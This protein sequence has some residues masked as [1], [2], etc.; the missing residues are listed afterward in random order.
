MSMPVQMHAMV[1]AAAGRPLAV[2]ELLVREPADGELLI[3][4]RACGVCRTD[5]HVVDGELREPKLPLVPGHEIIGTVAALGS[6]V[7]RGMGDARVGARRAPVEPVHPDRRRHP[8][9]VVVGLPARRV[10]GLGGAAQNWM[11]VGLQIARPSHPPM[12][13]KA[14][15]RSGWAK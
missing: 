9:G 12:A 7:D 4:V 8:R 11:G 1:L 6:V 15:W 3:K 14:Q 10:H 2:R 13:P 5:L